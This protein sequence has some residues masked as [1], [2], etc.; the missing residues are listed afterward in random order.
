MRNISSLKP[1]I[2]IEKEYKV[3][4]INPTYITFRVHLIK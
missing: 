1:Y 3:N 2:E 4:T